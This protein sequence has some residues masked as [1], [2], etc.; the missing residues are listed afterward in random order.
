[1]RGVPEKI[2]EGV[3]KFGVKVQLGADAEELARFAE[4]ELAC[5]TQ[6]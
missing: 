3:C 4:D 6:R 5:E 1:M 2:G